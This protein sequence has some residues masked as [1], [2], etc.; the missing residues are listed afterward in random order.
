MTWIL[1]QRLPWIPFPMRSSGM[2]ISSIV[3]LAIALNYHQLQIG[4][5]N[6]P[7][8][9]LLTS[10][11]SVDTPGDSQFATVDVTDRIAGLEPVEDGINVA[12]LVLFPGVVSKAILHPPFAEQPT[13][14]RL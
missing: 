6:L 13:L 10:G 4:S 5:E 1:A 8:I 11:Q 9:R 2:L 14:L 3:F 7:A 12:D